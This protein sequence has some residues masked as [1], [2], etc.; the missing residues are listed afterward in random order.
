MFF[1]KTCIAEV[2]GTGLIRLSEKNIYV[3]LV[4]VKAT[5]RPVILEGFV[6]QLLGQQYASE[7]SI[8]FRGNPMASTELV[9]DIRRKREIIGIQ[10]DL[11]KFLRSVVGLM[12][13]GWLALQLDGDDNVGRIVPLEIP[14]QAAEL[15]RNLYPTL[16]QNI[17]RKPE[18]S[19]ALDAQELADV[20]NQL[21][22]TYL[23][24]WEQ[25]PEEA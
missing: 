10:V 18:T 19:K 12:E 8:G 23:E 24:K 13:T 2:T 21:H 16:L 1:K 14:E 4:S 22:R 25:W 20:S 9:I 17:V 6:D 7:W 15:K 11:L 5:R 3:P